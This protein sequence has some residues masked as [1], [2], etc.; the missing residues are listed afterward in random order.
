VTSKVDDSDSLRGEAVD[1]LM[2]IQATPADSAA[3]AGLDAWLASSEAHRRAFRSVERVWTLTGALPSDM[4]LPAGKVVVLS[5][6]RRARRAWGLAAT[7]LAAGVALWFFPSLKLHFQ[8]DHLT[9]VAELRELTLEDG[10]IVH[11]DAASAIA[12]HYEKGRREVELLA[13]QAFFKVVSARDRPFV[14][15]AG[16]VAITVKGTAFDVWSSGDG[17][18][19]A[20]Q[21]GTVEVLVSGSERRVL[22]TLTRGERVVVDRQGAFARSQVDPD[23]VASWREH[24]LVVDGATLGE[25][26][27]ELGRHHR[28][29]IM[30]SDRKLA[31]RRIT[32]VFDLRRPLEALHTV[33]RTQHGS[34]LEI[35]PYLTIVSSSRP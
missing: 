20:V 10:S 1:W 15:T 24:R 25:V 11:L 19:V 23:D 6:V 8:A 14:V 31:D 27:E 2:R 3:R 30:M 9:G 33:A 35:S 26:V 28:G 16:N 32:G 5:R 34:V 13:G 7:V 29:V 17:V 18:S 22:S 21:S 4:P 12:V